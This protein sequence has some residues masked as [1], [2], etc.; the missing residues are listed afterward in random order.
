MT[1]NI[2]LFSIKLQKNALG[3]SFIIEYTKYRDMQKANAFIFAYK[4][5]GKKC[6][7]TLD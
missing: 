7:N 5:G 1:L 6:Q 3:D 4:I 2:V